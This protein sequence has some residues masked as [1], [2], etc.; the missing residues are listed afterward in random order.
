FLG[1]RVVAT[2][3]PAVQIDAGLLLLVSGLAAVLFP[4]SA[5]AHAAGD[6][7]VVKRYYIRGTLA[8]A[9]IL[10]AG[11]AAVWAL[12]P[13]LFRLWLGN[14]MD[15]TRAILP[16]VLIHTIIGGSAMVGRS[17][18]GRASCRERVGVGGGCG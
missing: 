16:L 2:Y 17:E 13:W 4:R 15:A 5:I 6:V 8:S 1:A 9:G 3:A 7:A 11:A 18:I 12:S 10:V 14:S